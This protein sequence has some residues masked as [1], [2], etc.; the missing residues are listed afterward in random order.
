MSLALV[1]VG[2]NT[3][4]VTMPA[5]AAACHRVGALKSLSYQY[6]ASL[7]RLNGSNRTLL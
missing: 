5:C 6:Q 2:Q 4:A 7:F 3:L 1:V